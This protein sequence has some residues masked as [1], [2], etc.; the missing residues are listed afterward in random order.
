M[1][2]SDGTTPRDE[3]DR[4]LPAHA[5]SVPEGAARSAGRP[6]GQGRAA[7]VASL[8]DR[9]LR[10]RLVR[11]LNDPRVQGMVSIIAVEVTSDLSQAIVKV[12]VLPEDRSRLTLSG[13]RSATKHLEGLVRKATRLRIVPQLRFELDESVKR[14]TRLMAALH[15][16]GASATPAEGEA[17]A[18]PSAPTPPSAAQGTSDRSVDQPTAPETPPPMP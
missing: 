1:Q 14:E 17:E 15:E 7:Q 9:V 12:S 6:A 18:T 13:L 16:A 11:G 2:A 5:W 8:I 3:S 4:A 10:E